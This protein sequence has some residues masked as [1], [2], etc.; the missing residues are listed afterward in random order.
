MGKEVRSELKP[1]V[2]RLDMTGTDYQSILKGPPGSVTMRSG[3]VQLS[4]GASVGEHSTEGR[5]ELIVVLEGKGEMRAAGQKPLVI[6]KGEVGYFPPETVHY[7]VN[8]G[9]GVFR[10]VYVVAKA[11]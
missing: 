10:Y 4:A 8:T 6:G 9:D 5:E 2:I 11:R 3:L 1:K 7:M